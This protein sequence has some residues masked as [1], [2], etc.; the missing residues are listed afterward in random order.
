MDLIPLSQ[1]IDREPMDTTVVY[2]NEVQHQETI[3]VHQGAKDDSP[4]LSEQRTVVP[5]N[6]AL[7]VIEESME[8]ME[9][10]T[11]TSCSPAS[12]ELKTDSRPIQQHTVIE[13]GAQKLVEEPMRDTQASLVSLL[14]EQGSRDAAT[15][16][17][18][19]CV[20]MAAGTNGPRTSEKA[21]QYGV[22]GVKRRNRLSTYR[23]SD[24]CE[25]QNTK[26]FLF[27]FSATFLLSSAF[28]TV[29]YQ[30]QA[31]FIILTDRSEFFKFISSTPLTLPFQQP[32]K[33]VLK[34]DLRGSQGVQVG[35]I[36]TSPT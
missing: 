9:W 1:L 33:T 17:S 10:L 31:L 32:V 24:T 7:L 14:G 34:R 35:K 18:H 28:D 16:T 12:E 26:F 2:V 6:A 25:L 4:I 23:I 19:E 30:L 21:C 13:I 20:D 36:L 15:S 3:R 11:D 29:P 5:V 27:Y 8:N 22:G